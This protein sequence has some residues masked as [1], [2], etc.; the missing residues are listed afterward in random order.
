M[1]AKVA[2]LRKI[3]PAG[4][5]IKPYYVQADF[6]KDSV[7]S[8]TDSLWIG[9]LLAI[10]VAIIFLRSA[11]A[12]V[13]ILI[14]IPV[15]ICLSLVAIYASGYTL[16]IMTLGA[17]AAAIGLIIDDAIV[18]VEQIHRSHEE[19][20]DEPNASVVQKAIHYLFPA[21]VGSSISTIVIFIPFELMSGVAGAYFKVMTNT[22]I[23]TLVCSFFVT[24]IFLPVIYLLLT[25]KKIKAITKKKPVIHEVK[26]QRW[27]SFFIRRPVISIVFMAALVV[28]I[29]LILPRL[30]TGFLPEMDEGSIVLD[31]SSPPGTSL[32]ETDRMLRQ[33]EKI[34]TAI[35][36]VAGLFAPHGHPNGLFYNRAQSRRLPYSAK[37]ERKRTTNDVIEEIR[38]KVELSQPALVIDFGQVIGDMLG[39]LMTSVQPIEIKIFGDNTTRL[40]QYASQVANMIDQVPGTADV[41]NGVVIAGPSL[42]IVPDNT[43]LAQFGLTPASFQAQVQLSLQGVGRGQYS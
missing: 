4:V 11:K 34:I 36:E 33:V 25:R 42:S 30:E 7:K 12:S 35:P 9:L 32:H 1:Q 24:W 14:T 38:H 6:V 3:L 10:I 41:F 23:I 15:T 43:R 21:M 31:Y 16:N 26:K 22:M 13:T 29:V 17:I 39:D 19:H 18:V 20:P 27:V 28:T 2:E 8:V 5:S 40:N 37:K